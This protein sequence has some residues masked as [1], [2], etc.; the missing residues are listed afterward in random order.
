[1]N[2]TNMQ[3]SSPTSAGAEKETTSIIERINAQ[4]NEE[5]LFKDLGGVQISRLNLIKSLTEQVQEADNKSEILESLNENLQEN[6]ESFVSRYII[7]S[8]QLQEHGRDTDEHLSSILEDFVYLSKWPIVDHLADMILAAEDNHRIALRAKVE[9]VAHL[10]G[11][12][13]SR[14]Y[15]ELL[16]KIDR[17]NP[18]VARKYG[19]AILEENKEEALEHLKRA[20]ETYARLKIIK[21]RKIYGC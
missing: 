11:K 8:L 19:L 1:M 5:R 2:T 9:S 20:G 16:T 7:G 21:D 6:Q 12:K 15:L 13:E 4:I 3:S 10:K 14:P 17:K 18:D